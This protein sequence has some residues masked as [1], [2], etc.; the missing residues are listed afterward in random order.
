MSLFVYAPTIK[1]GTRELIEAL[2]AKRLVRFDGMNFVHKGTPLKFDEA[3]DTIICWGG[4]VPPI[5]KLRI[6][7]DSL[8]FSSHL[9][10][11]RALGH[12]RIGHVVPNWRYC[13]IVEYRGKKEGLLIRDPNNGYVIPFENS[14]TLGQVFASN[15]HEYKV[16]M[17][18]DDIIN[19][20]VKKPLYKLHN[21]NT[22]FVPGVTSNKNVRSKEGGWEWAP[23]K[24][25]LVNIPN[26]LQTIRKQLELDFFIAYV[27]TSN[28]D[29]GGL[30]DYTYLRKINLSPNLDAD[31]VQMYLNLIQKWIKNNGGSIVP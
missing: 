29:A 19:V 25:K 22:I 13:P 7:N 27:I 28:P 26:H 17:F 21:M 4:N 31:G 20:Q 23:H 30:D 11:N 18:G 5:G 8:Y 10:T 1:P 3:E 14:P 12:M 24:G 2:G 16:I 9:Q 15:S 6:F